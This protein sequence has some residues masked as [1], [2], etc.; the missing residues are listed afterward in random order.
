MNASR[1]TKQ[2]IRNEIKIIQAR[3]KDNNKIYIKINCLC[4]G[5]WN[6]LE[7]LE[8]IEARLKQDLKECE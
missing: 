6:E 1:N 4:N 5:L 3:I 8:I 2:T 7:S